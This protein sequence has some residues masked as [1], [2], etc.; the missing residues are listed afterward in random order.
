VLI[1]TSAKRLDA[2][3]KVT[4]R[5]KYSYDISRPGMIYGKIVR[6]PLPHARIVSIDLTEAL[7][8][9]GVKTAIAWKEP[10]AEVMFQGDEVAAVAADTE[11]R[12]EKHPVTPGPLIPARELLGDILMAHKQPV[13]AL[14]AYE[15]TLKR[16]PNRT[17]TLLG[18]ARAARAAGGDDV[19]RAY[20]RNVIDLIDP[21]STRPELAEARTF[22]ARN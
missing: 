16:E 13:E 14:A 9:P 2:P 21:K 4:G 12:V 1:G 6:S 15:A 11:E 22:V 3:D 5:A 19:A 17:R 10:G 20:Y 18:A 7:K 8:A